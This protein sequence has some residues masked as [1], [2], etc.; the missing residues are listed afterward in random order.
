[1]HVCTTEC[2]RPRGLPVGCVRD[3]QKGKG[4]KGKGKKGKGKGKKK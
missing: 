1:M 2:S 4:K 3:V